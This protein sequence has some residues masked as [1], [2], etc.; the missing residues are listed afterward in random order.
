MKD[1]LSKETLEEF[2]KMI[3]EIPTLRHIPPEFS[4]WPS[5]KVDALVEPQ[6][7]EKF[8][9]AILWLRTQIKSQM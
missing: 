4:K 2:H 1:R 6:N 8:K 3:Q 7:L 5:I 9:K